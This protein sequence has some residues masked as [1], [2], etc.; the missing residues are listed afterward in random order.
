MSIVQWDTLWAEL[1]T[2]WNHYLLHDDYHDTVR[3]SHV[4]P[5]VIASGW[6]GTPGANE[7]QIGAVEQRL[8]TTLPPS[9][10]AFLKR[11]N[12]WPVTPM[13]ADSPLWPVAEIDWL[14]QKS[15]ALLDECRAR[16]VHPQK[17]HLAVVPGVPATNDSIDT[18]ELQQVLQISGMTMHGASDYNPGEAGTMGYTTSSGWLHD[19][20]KTV[21]ILNPCVVTDA[22]EW[23]AWHLVV[24]FPGSRLPGAYRYESFYALIEHEWTDY[25]ALH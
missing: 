21:Y 20:Y 19:Y 18:T 22:G 11:T 12:G 8:N 5:T 1:L 24:P 6:L 17:Y 9:Y 2:W 7:A 10:R 13:G 3:E 14:M 16:S 23:E 15:P 25:P 4:P